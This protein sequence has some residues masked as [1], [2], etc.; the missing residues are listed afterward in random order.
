MKGEEGGG[1]TC[2][3]YQWPDSVMTQYSSGQLNS[4]AYNRY[5]STSNGYD[6]V[7]VSSGSNLQG[8]D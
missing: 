2:I 3:K 8:F 4:T 7:S 1:S 5:Y 6:R